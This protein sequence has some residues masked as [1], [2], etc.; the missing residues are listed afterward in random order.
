MNIALL[1]RLAD[2]NGNI[3]I[4]KLLKIQNTL[5]SMNNLQIKIESVE[6]EF[7]A[8][9]HLLKIEKEKIQSS[10]DHTLLSYHGDPSGGRDSYMECDIC[11]KHL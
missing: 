7:K 9:M 5:M 6:K 2:K 1:K 4:D 10:C 3:N 11:G 8:E